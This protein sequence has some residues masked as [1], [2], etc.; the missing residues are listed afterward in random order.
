MVVKGF[1]LFNLDHLS[2]SSIDVIVGVLNNEQLWLWWPKVLDCLIWITCLSL[3][4]MQFLVFLR[5]FAILPTNFQDVK[6]LDIVA[7]H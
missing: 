6:N 7:Q 4:L 5:P 1:R 2:K 3:Q